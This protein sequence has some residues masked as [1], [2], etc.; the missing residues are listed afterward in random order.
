M[1]NEIELNNNI[2]LIIDSS[3]N[4]SDMAEL[5]GLDPATDFQ[6]VDLSNIDFSNSNLSEFRFAGSTLDRCDLTK[7]IL[8]QSTLRDVA[9]VRGAKL[10]RILS[11]SRGGITLTVTIPSKDDQSLHRLFGSMRR[12][13]IETLAASATVNSELLKKTLI[14]LISDGRGEYHPSDVKTSVKVPIAYYEELRRI[15][16]SMGT[17][18]TGTMRLLLRLTADSI[19]TEHQPNNRDEFVRV[20]GNAIKAVR[21]DTPEQG[22][23]F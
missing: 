9:S 5:V 1:A 18:F 14:D 23:L 12:A 21:S 4:F 8:S 10:P 17:P 20:F 13:I 15:A 19:Q 11:E 3:A 22:F 7:C 6:N 16:L 2:L